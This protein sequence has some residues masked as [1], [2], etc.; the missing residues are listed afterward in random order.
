MNFEDDPYQ[1]HDTIQVWRCGNCGVTTQT[2]I[3]D[4]P[5]D[6]YCDMESEEDSNRRLSHAWYRD[7]TK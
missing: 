7:Y 5:W 1:H 4:T 6:G 2:A 3:D